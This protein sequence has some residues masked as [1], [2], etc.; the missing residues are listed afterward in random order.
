MHLEIIYQLSSGHLVHLTDVFLHRNDCPISSRFMGQHTADNSVIGHDD[1]NVLKGFPWS[2][3]EVTA[4]ES[5]AGNLGKEA[6]IDS[7]ITLVPKA[8]SATLR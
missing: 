8:M 4:I 3:F 5:A 7:A 2:E 1:T 6:G